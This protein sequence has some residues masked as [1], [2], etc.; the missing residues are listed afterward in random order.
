MGR[1]KQARGC[2]IRTTEYRR[3]KRGSDE[4]IQTEG[5]SIHGQAGSYTRS[6][7]W[8]QVDEGTYCLPASPR[9][10]WETQ[11]A[12]PCSWKQH[13]PSVGYLATIP[14]QDRAQPRQGPHRCQRLPRWL[15]RIPYAGRP[16]EVQQKYGQLVRGGRDSSV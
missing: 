9:L 3:N 6:S 15:P 5:P 16:R 7:D 11:D 10:Q 4:I 8:S 14:S 2:S 1:P 13:D 12:V